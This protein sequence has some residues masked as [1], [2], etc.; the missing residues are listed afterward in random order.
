MKRR[1]W[2]TPVSNTNPDTLSQQ[3]VAALAAG[4]VDKKNSDRNTRNYKNCFLSPVQC[5]MKGR[6]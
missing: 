4:A 6:A 1:L 5:V 2:S 3:E